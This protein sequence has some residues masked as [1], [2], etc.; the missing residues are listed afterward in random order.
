MVALESPEGASCR[1]GRQ[2][3]KL[4]PGSF[5]SDTTA[6]WW[7]QKEEAK[8]DYLLKNVLE[9]SAEK[10]EGTRFSFTSLFRIRNP[11]TI[12]V[13]EGSECR[14]VLHSYFSEVR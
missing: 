14:Q 5:L 3:C 4:A 10:E 2:G 9:A 8:W 6:L 13:L 11:F 7:T 12:Q 1:A